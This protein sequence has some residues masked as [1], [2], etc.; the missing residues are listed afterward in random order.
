M[1]WPQTRSDPQRYAAAVGV[2]RR[3]LAWPHHV[4]YACVHNAG[5]A[6]APLARSS[7][8]LQRQWCEVTVHTTHCSLNTDECINHDVLAQ[9]FVDDQQGCILAPGTAFGGRDLDP[10]ACTPDRLLPSAQA[11][12]ARCAATRGCIAYTYLLPS[13]PTCAG[14]CYTKRAGTRRAHHPHAVSGLVS[15]VQ[16]QPAPPAGTPLYTNSPCARSPPQHHACT[17]PTLRLRALTSSTAAMQTTAPP[18]PRHA[19]NDAMQST[20]RE[21]CSG[22]LVYTPVKCNV[23]FF[24]KQGALPGPGTP[25]E[26]PPAPGLAT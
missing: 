11:C 21:Q 5:N 22:Y 12:C 26:Q 19:A 6:A 10:H 3:R 25:P 20:V 7:R 16:P 4:A 18:L 14:A 8:T 2:P 17:T 23:P 13:A 1:T 9:S 15:P 24:L